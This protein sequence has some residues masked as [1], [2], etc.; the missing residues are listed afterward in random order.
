MTVYMGGHDG[1]IR[2]SAMDTSSAAALNVV[3]KEDDL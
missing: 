2:R 1:I 3:D